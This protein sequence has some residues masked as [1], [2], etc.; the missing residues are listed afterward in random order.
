VE[1]VVLSQP[2]V[3]HVELITWRAPPSKFDLTYAS[4]WGTSEVHTDPDE[5]KSWRNV[6]LPENNSDWEESADESDMPAQ[7]SAAV[8]IELFTPQA[9]DRSEDTIDLSPVPDIEKDFDSEPTL[10]LALSY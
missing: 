2:A 4:F 8:D 1:G 3:E 9:T 7:L 5:D 10:E 6:D